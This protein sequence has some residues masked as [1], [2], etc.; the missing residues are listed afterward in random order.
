MIYLTIDILF[1]P[2]PFLAQPMSRVGDQEEVQ[3]HFPVSVGELLPRNFFAVDRAV[4]AAGSA[5]AIHFGIGRE[6]N[7]EADNGQRNDDRPEP[8]LMP[9]D[10]PKHNFSS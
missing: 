1:G 7:N 5:A 10:C 4:I 3:I 6:I 9:A 8:G 2:F